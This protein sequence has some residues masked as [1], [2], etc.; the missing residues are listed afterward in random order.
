MGS[1]QIPSHPHTVAQNAVECSTVFMAM[2]ARTQV[3]REDT[4][5]FFEVY[6]RGFCSGIELDRRGWVEYTGLW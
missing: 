5:S 3:V 2:A 4:Q 1:S 6:A